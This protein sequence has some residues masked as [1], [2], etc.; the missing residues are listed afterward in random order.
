MP[1][2][3][4]RCTLA[5][6]LIDR[7]QHRPRGRPA[8]PS[9]RVR[10]R[11]GADDARLTDRGSRARC[12][13]D[14]G[15]LGDLQPHPRQA[16]AALSRAA[17]GGNVGDAPA[18]HRGRILERDRR[19][20]AARSPLAAAHHER[21]DGSGDPLTARSPSRRAARSPH[22]GLSLGVLV[23]PLCPARITVGARRSTVAG[24]RSD[25]V[26]PPPAAIAAPPGD[27]GALREDI[28]AEL[29]LGLAGYAGRF[30]VDARDVTG[31]VVATVPG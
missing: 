16:R 3:R 2:M 23:P 25:R 28:G 11:I 31:I 17:S 5:R 13:H 15:K 10:R 6:R 1:G 22:C 4:E 12:C 9:L 30:G 27:R 24:R 14:I 8:G 18:G 26:R 19:L 20:R 7:Q 29:R 21:L